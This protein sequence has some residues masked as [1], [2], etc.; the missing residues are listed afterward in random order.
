M[1]ESTLLAIT[2]DPLEPLIRPL[3]PLDESEREG[4]IDI[5]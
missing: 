4:E 5:A 2:M 1:R 3:R